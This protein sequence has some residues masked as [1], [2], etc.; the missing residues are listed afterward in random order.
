MAVYAW[1][2]S[3]IPDDGTTP[4][5]NDICT[6]GSSYKTACTSFTKNSYTSTIVASDIQE[7]SLYCPTL[8][9]RESTNAETVFAKAFNP[10][11]M[12]GL[13]LAAAV[14]GTPGIYQYEFEFAFDLTFRGT[15]FENTSFK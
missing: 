10:A 7:R 2:R 1:D 4:T 3:G 5:V 6:Y 14:S 12:Y 9:L 15:R 8:K 13:E 11:F